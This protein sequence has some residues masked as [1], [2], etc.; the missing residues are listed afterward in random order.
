MVV[1]PSLARVWIGKRTSGDTQDNTL[2]LFDCGRPCGVVVFVLHRLVYFDI[3]QTGPG[4]VFL[5]KCKIMLDIERIG[6]DSR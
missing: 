6:G 5:N 2:Y 4:G 3:F 1:Y